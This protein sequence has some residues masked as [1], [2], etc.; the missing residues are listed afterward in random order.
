[1]KEGSL[2]DWTFKELNALGIE[3]EPARGRRKRD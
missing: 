2:D 3:W 1:M